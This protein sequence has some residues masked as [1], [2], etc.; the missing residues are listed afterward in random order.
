MKL[1]EILEQYGE[2]KYNEMIEEGLIDE[3][4]ASN[5]INSWISQANYAIKNK[6]KDY[7]KNLLSKLDS[8]IAKYS[9]TNYYKKRESNIIRL[10]E[11]LLEI[12]NPQKQKE[13]DSYNRD[14]EYILRFKDSW[15]NKYFA[16]YWYRDYKLLYT[17]AEFGIPVNKAINQFKDNSEDLSKVIAPYYGKY[18]KDKIKSEDQK[19]KYIEFGFEYDYDY[20][21][22]PNNFIVYNCN[23]KCA[24]KIKCDNNSYKISK[25]PNLYKP[26]TKNN[27][28]EIIKK[29]NIK[30]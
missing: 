16:N 12:Y 29:E 10:K 26:E 22:E 9:N 27:Y 14:K 3:Y 30:F 15:D 25:L 13:L 1:Y 20:D 11:K 28:I 18:S 4:K 17:L 19:Y 7:V 21:G 24:Q 23:L 5:E 6:V 2:D 8:I